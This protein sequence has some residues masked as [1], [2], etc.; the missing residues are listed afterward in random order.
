MPFMNFPVH[1]YTSCTDRHASPY[2]TFIRRWISMGFTPS[3]L[4]K[5]MTGRCSLVHVA[6]GDRH[7]YTT[8]VPSCCI[9]AFYCHLSA[10]LQTMSIIVV[11]LQ[12]IR[13]AFRIFIPLL[14]F[15]LI[16]LRTFLWS[17][18]ARLRSG[19]SVFQILAGAGDFSLKC[20]HGLWG[21]PIFQS[22]GNRG[23][24][25]LELQLPR[26]E[27]RHPPL[28]GAQIKEKCS[29]SSAFPPWP[30]GVYRNN[31]A[32]FFDL[33]SFISFCLP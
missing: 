21:N 33:L 8:T 28:C 4:K 14:G 13:A 10:T 12:D 18:V 5:R 16:L 7:L 2:W 31:F 26:C 6:S 32:F 25:S 9:P 24:L 23:T 17:V 3:L 20:P 30:H 27:V 15:H 1:P 22:K 11:N 29:C 19:R